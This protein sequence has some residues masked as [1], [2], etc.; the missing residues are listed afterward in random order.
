MYTYAS[1]GR[2][3]AESDPRNPRASRYLAID[4]ERLLNQKEARRH[5][6]VAARK[7]LAWGIPV[8]GSGLT[9][10]DGGRL[11][12]RGRDALALA[13]HAGFEDVVRLLWN[14]DGALDLAAAPIPVRCRAA[15]RQ[16]R[17]LPPWNRLQAILP[18]AAAD[19]GAALIPRR[20][21]GSNCLAHPDPAD[22]G[23][24]AADRPRV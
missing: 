19:A 12:Y 20:H 11:Y 16:L 1:R 3:H 14:A 17:T 18:F 7:T 22:R 24:D 23:G 9:L 10:I 15:L 6:D 21:V 2:I 13:R 5:P 4:V 8:L